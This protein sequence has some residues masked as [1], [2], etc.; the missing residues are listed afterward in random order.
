MVTFLDHGFQTGIA[1]A[2][3]SRGRWGEIAPALALLALG[4]AAL[5]V[6][7]LFANGVPGQYVVVTRP[8]LAVGQVLDLVDAA[9]GGVTGQGALPGLILAA[10]GDP[11]FPDRLRAGGAWLVLPSPRLPDCFTPAGDAR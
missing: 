10:S 3:A 2:T 9:G 6:A 4:L 5:T 11:D 1:P 8:G 7:I